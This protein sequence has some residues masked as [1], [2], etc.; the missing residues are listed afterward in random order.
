MAPEAV[1]AMAKCL[2]LEGD[3]ANPASLQHGFGERAHALIEVSYG[4]GQKGEYVDLVMTQTKSSK[5]PK[6]IKAH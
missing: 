5:C 1:A 3:F 2:T 6:N 4:S